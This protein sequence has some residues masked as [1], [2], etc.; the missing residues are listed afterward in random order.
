VR[1]LIPGTV[2]AALVA[3][4]AAVARGRFIEGGPQPLSDTRSLGDII[5]EAQ[6]SVH[7]SFVHG[8]R[9][10]GP[11]NSTSFR[12]ALARSLG[13]GEAVTQTVERHY[14][15]P[16]PWPVAA[17][18]GGTPIWNDQDEW[19][20][21]RPFVDRHTLRTAR[22]Q[23]V[24][25]EVN[26]WP[27]LFPIK[28]RFLLMPEHDLS[29]ND[30]EHLRLCARDD[31]P[32][33]AWLTGEQ[34]EALL[35]TR[36]RSGGGARLNGSIKRQILNWG[37]ADAV[38]LLG[39]MRTYLVAAMEQALQF[40]EAGAESL[41]AEERVLVSESLGSFLVMEAFREEGSAARAYLEQTHLLY[42]FAN[43]FALL[44]LARIDGIAE[45]G[46]PGPL[47]AVAAAPSPL[48]A[49]EQWG[50]ATTPPTEFAAGRRPAQ[51][52]AF[53]DPSDML[54]YRVPSIANVAVANVYV[55]NGPSLF[56]LLVDPLPAHTGHARNRTVL[57]LM[58]RRSR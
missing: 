34:L 18:V 56:G 50:A 32:Y 16:G 12:A 9:A 39:P 1:S 11:G 46:R 58:L 52:I 7:I 44:E 47:E 20:A 29:G 26:W 5:V 13:A 6:G 43:Q 38:I 2:L 35:N 48:S 22:V 51:I 40:A 10:E 49:L 14:L 33:H 55:R 15:D 45:P 37:L 23:V 53:S 24:V 8:M 27:L 31:G 21:S 3:A 25:D 4:P 30:R 54:T 19:L 36:P 17:T 57:D 41:A 42:F 28:C